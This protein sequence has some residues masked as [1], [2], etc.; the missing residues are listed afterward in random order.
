MLC[1]Y[2]LRVLVRVLD[3]S[4]RYGSCLGLGGLIGLPGGGEGEY[5]PLREYGLLRGRGLGHGLGHGL[6]DG[7]DLLDRSELLSVR[8]LLGGRRDRGRRLLGGLLG[9]LLREGRHGHGVRRGRRQVRAGRDGAFDRHELADTLFRVGHLHGGGRGDGRFV[10]GLVAVGLAAV[11]RGVVARVA[12]GRVAVDRDRFRCRDLVGYRHR[13]G[14][15]GLY[16]SVHLGRLRGV[17]VGDAHDGRFRGLRELLRLDGF[18]SLGGLFHGGRGFRQL[19]L[20]L[21]DLGL[22]TGLGEL[23]R[24]V[25]ELLLRRVRGLRVRVRLRVRGLH[26]VERQRRLVRLGRMRAGVVRL[27]RGVCGDGCDRERRGLRELGEIRSGRELGGGLGDLVGLGRLRSMRK[28][29]TVR[30]QRGLRVVLDLDHFGN[31]HCFGSLYGFR[32]L[33]N[34]RGVRSRY[35]LRGRLRLR[36]VGDGLDRSGPD[37]GDLGSARRVRMHRLCLLRLGRLGGGHLGGRLS[38]RDSFAPRERDTPGVGGVRG[39]RDRRG[40]VVRRATGVRSPPSGKTVS[41]AMAS[42]PTCATGGATCT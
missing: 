33:R 29:R 25:L 18:L 37:L 22:R 6:L 39:L 30:E 7:H 10:V 1:G 9:E 21:R 17:D 40:P 28:E 32:L 42:A 41:A 36:R 2:G 26:V 27:L 35:G 13:F 23:R 16:G 11:G 3:R 38:G 12:V 31:L 14:C 15:L 4:L 5:G 24:M 20:L 19:R 8:E 34:V